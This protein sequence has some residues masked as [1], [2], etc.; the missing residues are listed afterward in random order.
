MSERLIIGTIAGAVVALTAWASVGKVETSVHADGRVIPAGRTALVQHREGGVVE[1]I[2]VREGQTVSQGAVLARISSAQAGADLAQQRVQAEALRARIVRLQA[3][4][5]GLDP[6]WSGVGA[7]VAAVEKAALVARQDRLRAQMRELQAV[8]DGAA[9]RRAQ[10]DQ[11]AGLLAGKIDRLAGLAARGAGAKAETDGARLEL[12]RVR[13]ALAAL[14]AEKARAEAEMA[15]LQA[16]MALKA[17][18]E[19]AAATA[20]L[21]GLEAGMAEVQD[22]LGRT[23]VRAPVAGVVKRLEITSTGA[24]VRPGGDVAELVPVGEDLVVEARV[25]PEDL[26]RLAPGQPA[27]VRMSAWDLSSTGALQGVVEQISPD[28]FIDERSGA[29]FYTA[30][31]ATQAGGAEQMVAPGMTATV[32]LLTGERRVIDYLLGPISETLGRALREG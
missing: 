8:I 30:R 23:D 31:V 28:V 5:T 25:R 24:V 19:L 17:Q 18:E 29:A 9:A 15:R 10:L 20:E 3:E 21:A 22:R 6:D 11:Q 4:A 32:D 7:D 13:E 1:E 27:L 12:A 14:P 2:L 26:G 16:E